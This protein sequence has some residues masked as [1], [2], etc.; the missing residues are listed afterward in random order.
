MST[1]FGAARANGIGR[2]ASR[3]TADMGS[4]RRRWSRAR[5]LVAL[6]VIAL[7]A[8]TASACGTSSAPDRTAVTVVK[9]RVDT[10]GVTWLCRPGLESNP[11]TGSLTTTI[12]RSSGV[13]TT[14]RRGPAPGPPIDCFYVYPTV[15]TEATGNAN[16]AVQPA[17]T[18]VANAQAAQFSRDC[19]VYAPMYRQATLDSLV[20]HSTTPVNPGEAYDDVLAAWHDYLVHYNHGRGFVL[21]GHS[22]GAFILKQLISQAVEGK[23]SV[24]HRLVSAILLGGNVTVAD[25]KTVGG[26]FTDVPAC[27]SRFE[28]GCVIAYSS[29]AASSPPPPNSVFARTST[30]GRH[31]L[32]TDPAAL[33]GGTGTLR[34]DVPTELHGLSGVIGSGIAPL[35]PRVH[36]PWVSWPDRF[37]AECTTSG[38][39]T[40]LSV[41]ADG[42]S[43]QSILAQLSHVLPPTWGLHL[44]DVNLALGNLVSIVADQGARFVHTSS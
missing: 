26:S 20:G 19:R 40:W 11:C 41:S 43:G 16:L 23:P 5:P 29:F 14:L 3:G 33:D 6:P 13:R 34:A 4:A 12:V 30:P 37:K 28:T 36:T 17:E 2:G 7:L 1:W 39:A 18:G 31:V 15:S 42:H 44:V 32:C 35:V 25:G 24:R 38:G 21:I 10:A 22:Q 9:N 8:V 27:R